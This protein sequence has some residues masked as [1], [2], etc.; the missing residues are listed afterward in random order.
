MGKSLKL[1]LEKGIPVLG[2]FMKLT[3]PAVAEIFAHAGFD[4][5]IID[6]EHGPISPERV[7]DMVRGCETSGVVPIIRVRDN[8]P[9]LISQALDLGGM[10]IQVPQIATGS[11]ALRA[12]RAAKFAPEGDRGVCRYVRAAAYSHQSK[13]VYFREANRTT[14][15]IVQV[16]GE[17]GISNIA[18]ILA[19]KG[20][21]VVFI[22]PYDLSQSLG[23]PGD[24]EHPRVQAK[25][26]EVV[27]T[28]RKAGLAVG[29][30]VD[31]VQTAKKWLALGV[32][33]IAYSVDV[34]IIHQA[35]SQV[36]RLI[37]KE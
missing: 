2:S 31:D 8:D 18:E 30:F 11:A 7:E 13:N 14:A 34:G 10:A 1:L 33:F 27:A 32:Q 3:D 23:V 22:G 4:F 35:A 21:D 26:M 37:S 19:V 24:V 29:T 36:V 15:V 5:V 9:T 12:V 17:E 25:M 28:A 16:E 6:M 20:I